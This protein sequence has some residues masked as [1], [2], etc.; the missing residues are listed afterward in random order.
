MK[1]RILKAFKPKSP[2]PVITVFWAARNGQLLS[3]FGQEPRV[4]CNTLVSPEVVT[5]TQIAEALGLSPGEYCQIE[6]RR[7][8]T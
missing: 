1:E 6:I 5:D 2:T 3:L 4:V 8:K 7:T